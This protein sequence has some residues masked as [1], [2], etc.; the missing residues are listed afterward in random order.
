MF[1]GGP[2]STTCRISDLDQLWISKEFD[3]AVRRLVVG[4]EG[5]T[6]SLSDICDSLSYTDDDADGHEIRGRT[7][8]TDT[9]DDELEALCLWVTRGGP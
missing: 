2:K 6:V 3:R 4:H 9:A 7:D 1:Y 5:R 8:S